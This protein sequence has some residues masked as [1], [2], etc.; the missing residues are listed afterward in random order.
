MAQVAIEKAD[1]KGARAAS[2]LD[3]M[4]AL[5]ERIRQRA[6][7]IFEGRGGA[8]GLATDDWLKAERDLI[9][10]PESELVEKD[11]IFEVRVSAPGFDPGNVEVTAL[12]DALI[13]KASS[14]HK[15]DEI[16]ENVRFC[17]FGQKTLYRRFDLPEGIN[18]DKVSAS[19]DKGVLLLTAL[20]AKQ[21][22]PEKPKAVAA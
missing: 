15:H 3:E 13:V 7:E 16:K 17:E 11:G 10:I 2:I 9:R 6:F 20:K 12:P 8:D 18:V 14:T 5:S 22:T 19:L 21:Q 4:K 1:G